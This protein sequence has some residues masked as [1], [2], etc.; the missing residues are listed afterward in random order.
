M[1]ALVGLRNTLTRTT[2]TGIV[3]CL[4][5]SPVMGV[6]TV[7]FV[8]ESG[9]LRVSFSGSLD[10]ANTGISW[11]GNLWNSFGEFTPDVVILPGVDDYR[12]IGPSVG[13]S[14]F[15][16]PSAP[17][18]SSGVFPMLDDDHLG[19]AEGGLWWS[20]V[21]VTEGSVLAPTELTADPFRDTMFFDGLTLA[22]VDAEPGD[23]AEGTTLWTA[24]NGSNDTFIFSRAVP[25]PEPSS[26]ALLFGMAAS[27][28]LLRRRSRRG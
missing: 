12:A 15:L 2:L 1:S 6:M 4:S 16:G 17:S 25:V 13:S 14:S 5:V 18:P 3:A 20:E 26:F 28:A 21:H 8:E 7:H 27:L 19:F 9:G 24:T 23:I 22:D 11:D 10:L